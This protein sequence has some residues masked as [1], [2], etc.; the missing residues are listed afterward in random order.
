MIFF[1]VLHNGRGQEVPENYI[2]C[3]SKEIHQ[4]KW[5]ISPKQHMVVTV[6]C[7]KI[8]FTAIGPFL[9]QK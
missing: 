5:G 4:G 3:F 9:T 2:I 1:K 7:K 6:F 8:L